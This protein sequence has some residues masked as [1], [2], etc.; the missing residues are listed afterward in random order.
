MKNIA[1]N[2][3]LGVATGD[4][5]G[6]PFE[7]STREAMLKNPA[8]DMI[9]F[10]V[11][12]QLPGTWSDDSSMTFCLAEAL[13]KDYNLSRVAQNFINWKNSAYWSAR[14]TVFD[15]GMTTSRAIS[16]LEKIISK[17]NAEDFSLLRYEAEEYD[18]GNGSLMRILPLIFETYGKELQSQ[19]EIIWANSSLTHRHIRAAMACMIY[20]KMA[21]NLIK[22]Q[23]K[24]Q[25]YQQTRNEINQ[26]WDL[27]NFAAAE[28]ENFKRVIQTDI[29]S[30]QEKTIMSGGYVIESLEASLW[31]LLITDSYESAV[32]KSINL[33][34]DTDT[35]GAITG[36]LAG[37]YYGWQNIPQY[38][39]VNLARL[40]D[41]LDLGDKLDEKYSF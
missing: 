26:L 16:R 38:W 40:E 6:V 4:A 27:M 31:S 3:L 14:G 8:T 7:F 13:L 17:N 1:K 25:A 24:I 19:F 28:R 22:T 30:Y 23:N 20:L 21:E 2:I 34:H 39:I 35:T 32:L 33:G 12:N 18:N 37:I 36:G 11:H 41:I 29:T 10:K 15:I 9:G 5:L